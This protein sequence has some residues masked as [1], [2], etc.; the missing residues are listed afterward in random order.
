MHRPLRQL[1][2]NQVVMAVVL[3]RAL[4]INGDSKNDITQ[5][6]KLTPSESNKWWPNNINNK[7]FYWATI[8]VAQMPMG[9]IVRMAPMM[10][11]QAEFHPRIH[12]P[13]PTIIVVLPALCQV[14]LALEFWS[15]FRGM[16]PV[17]S[18]DHREKFHQNYKNW[19]INNLWPINYSQINRMADD[20]VPNRRCP[21]FHPNHLPPHLR[22]FHRHPPYIL[23]IIHR[24][25]IGYFMKI[26]K[27]QQRHIQFVPQ[28]PHCWI[29]QWQWH[30]QAKC[31]M[32]KEKRWQMMMKKA[33]KKKK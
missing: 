21:H 27:H 25:P 22:A 19:W 5:L 33:T 26:C 12:F 31:W 6:A 32:E 8:P 9:G 4:A 1:Q 24:P 13:I 3:H 20:S 28:H 15:D 23:R 16:C 14:R 17:Q 30:Q 18:A 2:T 10:H 29:V 7:I 11:P